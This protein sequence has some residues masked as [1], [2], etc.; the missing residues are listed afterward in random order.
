MGLF[1]GPLG[2]TIEYSH[3]WH[4][5]ERRSGKMLHPDSRCTDH[6]IAFSIVRVVANVVFSRA[7]SLARPGHLPPVKHAEIGHFCLAIDE[8]FPPAAIAN[9]RRVAVR[10]WPSRWVVAA[11]GR[12]ANGFGSGLAPAQSQLRFQRARPDLPFHASCPTTAEATRAPRL[13]RLLLLL[14]FHLCSRLP[15][16]RRSPCAST[17][18][19]LFIFVYHAPLHYDAPSELAVARRVPGRRRKRWFHH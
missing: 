5:E 18:W 16:G 17:T 4:A 1:P 13:T 8:P 12:P 3:P 15:R 14:F 19:R 2:L 9:P 6:V 7:G 10:G 11:K